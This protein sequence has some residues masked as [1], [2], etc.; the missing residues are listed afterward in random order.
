MK[1]GVQKFCN[2]LKKLDSGFRRNDKKWCFSTFYE[3]INICYEHKINVYWRYHIFG[4]GIENG[5]SAFWFSRCLSYMSCYIRL[6]FK[7]EQKQNAKRKSDN[8]LLPETN[9][10][11]K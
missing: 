7:H 10:Q 8:S 3:F 11:D 6:F 5:R 2:Q 4:F 9:S 1:I